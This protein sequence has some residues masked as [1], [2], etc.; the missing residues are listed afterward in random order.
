MQLGKV[1]RGHAM[2]AT[3]V[4]LFTLGVCASLHEKGSWAG[5]GGVKGYPLGWP[6]EAA[7]LRIEN[8]KQIRNE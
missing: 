6:C 4:G 3:V 7:G 8:R 1:G 2:L 5:R